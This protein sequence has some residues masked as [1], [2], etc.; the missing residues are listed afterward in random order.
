MDKKETVTVKEE[1]VIRP[2]DDNPRL[3][4]TPKILTVFLMLAILGAFS[5]FLLSK[6]QAPAASDTPSN[7]T[8]E[9]V[10]KGAIFGSNDLKTFKDVAEGTLEEG[11]IEGEGQFHLV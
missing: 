9:S 2:L 11:G 10:S 3:S 4:F 8:A 6:T 7:A 1:N 5:G